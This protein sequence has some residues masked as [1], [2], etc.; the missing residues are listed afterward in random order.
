[1]E[2]LIK[3][4]H[5]YLDVLFGSL[6]KVFE[7]MDDSNCVVYVPLQS[8]GSM[9]TPDSNETPSISNTETFLLL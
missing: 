7:L 4:I 8:A 6:N 9:E 5:R 2:I 1:M 3:R